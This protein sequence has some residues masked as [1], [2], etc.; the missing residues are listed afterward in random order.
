VW[1]CG[2]ATLAS[3]L[4]YNEDLLEDEVAD[5]SCEVPTDCEGV[6]DSCGFRT[7][8]MGSCGRANAGPGRPCSENGGAVCDGAGVCVACLTEEHCEPGESCSATHQC[9]T[10]LANNGDPC[11]SP[12]ICQSGHC[13]EGRCCADDCAGPCRSCAIEGSEGTCEAHAVDTD[14]DGDCAPDTCN[15]SGACRCADTEINGDESDVDCGGPVCLKCVDGDMCN[16]GDDCLS[17]FCSTTCQSP[18]CGDGTQQGTEECDDDN[19]VSFDG[20]SATCR[21]EANHLL[22]SEIVVSPTECE[23]IEIYNPTAQIV[24]LEDVYLADVANYYTV[25]SGPVAV[26][27]S[28]FVA[29]FPAGATIGPHEFVVVST[30]DSNDT[31]PWTDCPGLIPDFDLDPTDSGAPDLMG[32]I[33][34]QVTLTS[35]AEVIVLFSWDGTAAI[36]DDLDYLLYGDSGDAVDKTGVAGYQPDTDPLFQTF[37]DVH[38]LGQSLHRCDTAESTETKTGG[39]GVDG[40]DE[41]SEDLASAFVLATPSPGLPPSA[42]VCR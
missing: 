31:S 25:T 11:V 22:I 30:Q 20:C 6:D 4:I 18:N 21:D 12:A 14:P 23:Y 38:G 15:G 9:Q 35:D 24:D 41:T 2:F 40:H 17:G 28:D 27:S 1:A 8:D 3:C 34:G 33:G 5:G 36:V 37:P 29:H 26:A 7:C 32:N 13:V 42:S 39:N 19:T 16:S 10:G